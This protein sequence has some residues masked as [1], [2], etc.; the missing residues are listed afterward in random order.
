MQF[1]PVESALARSRLG[2]PA[3]MFFVLAAAAPL[4]VVA[5]GATTAYA[6]TG[7]LGIPVAY[8]LIASVLAVF[9]VGYIAMSRRI[10]NA[11]AFYT[12]VA[13]G[14][15]RVPGVGAAFVAVTA[16]AAL[17]FGMLGGVGAVLS[18]WLD[19]RFETT[20][21]WWALALAGALVVGFLGVRKVD[22]NGRVLAVLLIGEVAVSVVVSIVAVAHP[23]GGAVTYDTLSPGVLI[24]SGAGAALVVAITGF[25][26]FEQ[27]AVF[28]EESRDPRRT[29][30]R[31][32]H[33]AIAVPGLLY[34]FGSW[35]M[36]VATGPDR[37]VEQSRAHGTEL[38][39][40]IAGPHVAPF[41]IDL[42]HLL[43]ITSLLA[44]AMAFHNT[45]A[46]YLF[47]LGRERVLPASLGHTSPATRAPKVASTALTAASALVI[48]WYAINGLDPI[49]HLFFWLTVLGGL[50]VLILMVAT[51]MAVLL[52]FHRDADRD[53]L[54]VWHRRI[55][56][57]LALI[58][59]TAILI[60]TLRQFATV[61]G[62]D[63]T[64]PLRWLLPAVFGVV[65]VLGVAWALR[66]RATNP[67]VYAGIGLGA[68]G[69]QA[70]P[71]ATEVTS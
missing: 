61:A 45:T 55:A 43:L 66:I 28:A 31:A 54:T 46:R 2:V 29:V 13:R 23:A 60:V 37:I 71:H 14:L 9:S 48:V 69:T 7:V 12:Y 64:S 51:S 63:P 42:G 47:S 34:A 35:A 62:V 4:T 8:L 5:G 53:G 20:V 17:L 57:A 68:A 52:Y 70:Q 38:L 59:L 1:S 27:T 22:L 6:V 44:G 16:Y 49:V 67:D 18:A 40:T 39:F 33:L 32:T 26:G 50:G 58:A 56:P 11:G 15:G 24:G 3:V 36:S 10:V 41:L 21:W 19:T 65:A 30:P 25:V